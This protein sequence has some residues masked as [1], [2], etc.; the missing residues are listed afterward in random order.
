MAC[1]VEG[2]E[3]VAG[4][5]PL[6]SYCASQSPDMLPAYPP[7]ETDI[8]DQ[9]H[10]A[11]PSPSGGDVDEALIDSVSENVRMRSHILDIPDAAITGIGPKDATVLW[12][13]CPGDVVWRSFPNGNFDTNRRVGIYLSKGLIM[14][15]GVMTRAIS[16]IEGRI[17]WSATELN[18]EERAKV[19]SVATFGLEGSVRCGVYNTPLG[20][21]ARVWTVIMAIACNGVLLKRLYRPDAQHIAVY[22][23]SRQWLVDGPGALTLRLV[24]PVYF[25]GTF[26][27]HSVTGNDITFH[28]SVVQRCV[29]SSTDRAEEGGIPDMPDS[30]IKLDCGFTE[31]YHS[32]P[33]AEE[34]YRQKRDVQPYHDPFSGVFL[35]EDQVAEIFLAA[36][37]LSTSEET[38]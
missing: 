21:V 38:I 18:D 28:G 14:D 8:L 35:A 13:L 22:L 36:T 10:K 20:S 17:Y 23:H 27:K 33:F 5:T 19:V 7:S 3:W 16:K 26:N 11:P 9:K 2:G 25:N 29:I 1:L 32:I 34:L 15:L 24:Y 31:T 30:Y 4:M 37:A 12:P 6:S